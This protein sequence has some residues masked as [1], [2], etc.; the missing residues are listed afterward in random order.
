MRYFL[1]LVFAFSCNAQ[2][3]DALA[4]LM[5]KKDEALAKAE[6]TPPAT[7]IDQRKNA[8]RAIY[9][10]ELKK[11]KAKFELDGNDVMVAKVNAEISRSPTVQAPRGHSALARE[12]GKNKVTISARVL[13]VLDDGL[14]FS[15]GAYG[16]FVLKNH[17]DQAKLADGSVV[18]CYAIKSDDVYSYIDLQG[19]KRTSRLFYYFGR[20]LGN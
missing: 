19:A 5:L 20:K 11:L 15:S 14:L 12:V 2:E 7:T 17:P 10:A 8:I 1:L 18:H 6:A 16:T 13:Q 9:L 3:T 4:N